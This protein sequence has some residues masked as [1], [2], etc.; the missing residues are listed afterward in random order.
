MILFGLYNAS[1]LKETYPNFS[2]QITAK[3]IAHGCNAEFMANLSTLT[4]KNLLEG[5]HVYGTEP[6]QV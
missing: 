2:S 1:K 5:P 3:K 4:S 6:N